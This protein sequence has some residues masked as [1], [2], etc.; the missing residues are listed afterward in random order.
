MVPVP[1]KDHDKEALELY[2]ADEL[3][4]RYFLESG[5]RRKGFSLMG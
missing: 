4:M 3:T 5:R 2:A 1:K